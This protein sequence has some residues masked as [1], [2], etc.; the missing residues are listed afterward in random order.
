MS[1]PRTN[2]TSSE[3]SAWVDAADAAVSFVTAVPV[4]MD[5]SA[6][7]EV[8]YTGLD[9]AD[10]WVRLQ[11]SNSGDQTRARDL[12]ISAATM[13]TANSSILFNINEIGYSYLHLVYDA[14]SNSAGSITARLTRK[15]TS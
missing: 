2:L 5:G 10:G 15:Q 3:S 14:G 12:T 1:L 6:S 8:V 9:A 4:M 13:T 11:A 7:V